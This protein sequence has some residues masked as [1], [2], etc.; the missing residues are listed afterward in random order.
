MIEIQQVSKA[1]GG[2]TIH[3]G[4]S[5]EIP[6]GQRLCIVGG[7]GIGKSVLMKLILGLEPLDEG[8]IFFEG[9][10]VSLLDE[11]GLFELMSDCGVVF[12]HAALFDSLTIGENIGLRLLENEELPFTEIEILVKEALSKVQLSADVIEMLPSQLSGG[13]QKRA[14]IAR[15]IIH[16]PKYLFYDE[17]TTGLDPENAAYIDELIL[18]LS[19]EEETTSLI[20]THDLDTI[21]RVA[22][23]VAMFGPDGLIYHGL[24]EEFW[25]STLPEIEAFLRRKKN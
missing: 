20:I 1:F 23:H 8:E 25:S 18:D 14:A 2:K 21:K 6:A 16:K 5:M 15:A 19:K 12:Q 3:Q 24:A 22:S 7:S 10:A 17:P 4:L 11:T 9:K 13:M